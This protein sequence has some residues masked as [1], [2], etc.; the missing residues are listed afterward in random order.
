MDV[1]SVKSFWQEVVFSGRGEPPPERTSDAAVIAFVRANPNAVG[2][3]SDATPA[4]SV[5]VISV[6][7]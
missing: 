7:R 4:E 6:T 2:Y 1:P 5:K 3:I